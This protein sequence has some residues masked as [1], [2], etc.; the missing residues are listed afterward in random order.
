[1]Y[2]IYD[3]SYGLDWIGSEIDW[4]RLGWIK[5]IGPMSNSGMRCLTFSMLSTLSFFFSRH[6]RAARRFCSR[7]RRRLIASLLGSPHDPVTSIGACTAQQT[8]SNYKKNTLG[9]SVVNDISRK[10]RKNFL[11]DAVSGNLM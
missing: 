1:M 8:R 5:K 3:C 11:R 2:Y 9:L 10:S 6:L 7:R 4:I